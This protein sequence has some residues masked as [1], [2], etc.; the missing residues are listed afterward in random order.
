VLNG[1]FRLD[2]FALELFVFEL[3]VLEFVVL[4]FAVLG[5]VNFVPESVVLGG[6]VPELTYLLVLTRDTRYK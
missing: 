2:F 3:S 6:V 4:E 1:V 5:F